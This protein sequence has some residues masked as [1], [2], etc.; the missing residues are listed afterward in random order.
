LPQLLKAHPGQF[1][2]V[3]AGKVVDS[4][5]NKSALARRIR[6]Q[7]YKPVYIHTA[8]SELRIVE[9]PAPEVV[10]RA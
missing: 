8:T 3:H 4:D 9:A 1:V 2:A 10:R 5:S 6:E 7:G